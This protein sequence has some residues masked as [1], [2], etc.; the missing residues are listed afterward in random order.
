MAN[1]SNWETVTL[2][3]KLTGM[4]REAPCTVSAV[5]LSLPDFR[6]TAFVRCDILQAPS[7]LPD[8]EYFVS[9][10][11]RNML[12]QKEKGVWHQGV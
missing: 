4:G 3:T 12:V 10:G 6:I 5:K 7:D 11:N 8:G 2:M 1:K 9:L